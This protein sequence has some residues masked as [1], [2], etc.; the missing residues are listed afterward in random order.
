[1]L[2]EFGMCF[3]VS[4]RPGSVR[5]EAL[6]RGRVFDFKAVDERL[7]FGDGNGRHLRMYTAGKKMLCNCTY[8]AV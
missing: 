4:A 6:N 7:D 8:N 2:F 3:F 1:M 5:N